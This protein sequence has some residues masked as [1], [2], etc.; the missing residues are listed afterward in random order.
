LNNEHSVTNDP[1][2]RLGRVL[3]LRDLI[4]YGIV[5]IQPIAAIPVFGVTHELSRGHAV[6]AVLIAGIAMMLTGY[7]YGRMAALHPAAGSAYSYVGRGLNPHLGFLA[8]WAMA[9][10]YLIFPIVALIQASLT[11]ER[12]IPAIP[13]AAWV[14]IFVA[15]L[16]GINLRGIRTTARANTIL[17]TAM[18][19]V[20][21]IF[22]FYASSF[23]VDTDGVGGLLSSQP[24]YDPQTF[25]MSALATATAFAALTYIGFDGVTTLGEDVKN[26]KRNVMLATMFICIFTTS[27]SC[28][29]IYLAQLAWPQHQAFANVE[30][31]FMDVAR[32]VGGVALFQAFGLV[33]MVGSLGSGM[34]A[35]VA[36]GRLLF[37]MGRDDVLPRKVFGGLNPRTNTPSANVIMIGVLALIGALTLSL[38]HAGTLLNFG[39]FLSFMGVNLAALRQ[40]YLLRAH[41]SQRRLAD[42]LIPAA[43]FLFCLG[44][45]WN[46]PM[47]AK[48]VGGLWFIAGISYAAY[49]TKGFRTQPAVLEFD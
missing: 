12:L 33:M 38:E 28:L 48:I 42:L 15:L 23:V 1:A 29:L 47:L 2:P 34:S 49:R 45:W 4:F 32:L 31:A 37:A 44:M 10:D 46:L 14:T 18:F 13:Y 25:N 7:S 41:G 30:T 24:F 27:F 22:I 6:T 17:L 11:I 8:G 26:P 43:G 35:Q 21:A 9:L 20:I 36:A 19:V 3:G 5:I 16:T 40:C 39:A